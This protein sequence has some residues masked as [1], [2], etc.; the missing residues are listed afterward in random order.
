MKILGPDLHTLTG[1]YALDAIDGGERERF[2]RHLGRCQ[3]C[4]HEVRGLQ[5]TAGR[6]GVAVARVPPPGLKVAVLTSA[7]QIRQH[8][9][10][11]DTRPQPEPRAQRRP[12]LAVTVATVAVAAAV[13]L[14]V[15]L[16]IQQRQLDRTRS[17]L[18]Q[19]EATEQHRLSVAVAQRAAVVA[20]ERRIL[21]VLNAPDAQLVSQHSLHGGRVIVVAAAHQHKIVVTT[22]NLRGLPGSQVYQLWFI[23]ATGK[24]IVSAGLLPRAL[25]GK[26]APVLAKGLKAGDTVAMT[27]EPAGGT[28]QPTTTVLVNIAV[29]AAAQGGAG[30]G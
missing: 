29:P 21:G 23:N 2:E 11:V 22:A 30:T 5:E 25:N 20:K 27:A 9:P 7:A 12:R 18:H 16:G 10:L 1:A 3:S 14:G 6:L 17:Q 13:A 15:V 8:P 4:D 26:T 28:A 19:I 24:K